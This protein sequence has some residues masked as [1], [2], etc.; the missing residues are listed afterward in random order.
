MPTTPNAACHPQCAAISPPSSTPSTDPTDAVAKNAPSS[1]AR[2]R[3]G[4]TLD[5]SAT[6]VEP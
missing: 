4:N 6:P 2:I 3:A 1:A 5:N